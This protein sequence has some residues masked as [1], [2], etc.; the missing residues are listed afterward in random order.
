MFGVPEVLFRNYRFSA[1]QEEKKHQRRKV[2]N[3]NN[4]AFVALLLLFSIPYFSKN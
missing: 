2:V 3:K 1:S 4:I